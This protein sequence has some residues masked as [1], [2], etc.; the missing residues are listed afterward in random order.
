MDWGIIG[1]GVAV[2]FELLG[3]VFLAGRR[4]EANSSTTRRVCDLEE[5]M[6]QDR[7]KS[8]RDDEK[9]VGILTDIRK[10]MGNISSSVAVINNRLDT[11]PCATR[12]DIIELLR[13]RVSKLEGRAT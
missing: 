9:V 2:G 8:E 7:N 11:L 5:Q 10:E 1:L 13:E 6:K 4:T 3:I 12:G